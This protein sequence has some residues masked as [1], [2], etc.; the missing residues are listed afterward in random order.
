MVDKAYDWAKENLSQG[1]IDMQWKKVI[2]KIEHPLK[3]NV[4]MEMV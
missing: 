2:D 3:Y 1:V 4:V